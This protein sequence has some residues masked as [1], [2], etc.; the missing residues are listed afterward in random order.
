MTQS[1]TKN[2]EG[3][4]S[5]LPL[6]DEAPFDSAQRFS[7][8]QDKVEVL[9]QTRLCSPQRQNNV[10]ILRVMVSRAG[11][12]GRTLSAVSVNAS[13]SVSPV[14]EPARCATVPK[15]SRNEPV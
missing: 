3:T 11:G 6:L 5:F 8:P 10:E 7:L 4:L 9:T 2:G 12:S 15:L 14:R 1:P 13:E